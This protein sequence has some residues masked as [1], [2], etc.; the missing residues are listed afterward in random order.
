MPPGRKRPIEPSAL[1]IQ[2]S[3]KIGASAKYE[4]HKTVSERIPED[5]TRAK[6]DAWL[7]ILSPI[8]QWAGLIGDKLAHKRDLL[9]IQQEE[10]LTAIMLRAAP[11]LALLR[12]PIKPVP[13]KFLVPF[14]EYASL[15]EPD[16][17][18]VK[19]WANLLVSSA[20]NYHPD[21]VYY[22]RLISQMSSVQARL[23]EAM[24]GPRG[25][26][27]VLVSMEENFFL[28]Q[29]FLA[30]R[31]RDAFGNAKKPP[32]TLRQA[33]NRLTKTLNMQGVV[34]EHIDVGHQVKEDYTNGAPP[35]SLY[36]DEQQNDY[37]ILRGLG[38]IEYIDTG[39][40][41]V[42]DQWKI[43]VMAHYVSPLGLNFAQ[44]CGVQATNPDKDS[45]D[46]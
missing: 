3:A 28:G 7:T 29:N 25:P 27:S 39:F 22:V 30:D 20:E 24:I 2:A 40:F 23:F 14:L 21:N 45:A 4:V 11:R 9:R 16:S 13:V 36:R 38:L 34:I 43:K 37:A 46:V 17:E 5:V 35:Y 32:S 31:I 42:L 10:T 19:M 44:A 8:T 33:W 15:E 41:V 12:P 6:H 26:Q 1:S 18:L